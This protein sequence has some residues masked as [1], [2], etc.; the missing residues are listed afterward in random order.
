MTDG[1]TAFVV[2]STTPFA[3]KPTMLIPRTLVPFTDPDNVIEITVPED[4]DATHQKQYFFGRVGDI[5]PQQRQE[6]LTT[7]GTLIP[8]Q[9]EMDFIIGHEAAHLLHNHTLRATWEGLLAVLGSHLAIKSY[10][11]LAFSAFNNRIPQMRGWVHVLGMIGM[12]SALTLLLTW[13]QEKEADITSAKKLGCAEEATELVKKVMTQNSVMEREGTSWHDLAHPPL[14]MQLN[15]MSSLIKD[16][17]SSV[18][19]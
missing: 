18:N 7:N 2:G 19:K 10:N 12:S 13:E 9:N 17:E 1:P 14:K 4:G 8:N 15:Y 5:T 16:K 11:K 3:E 6:L